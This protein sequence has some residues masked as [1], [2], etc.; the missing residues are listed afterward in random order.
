MTD[1]NYAV[2][3]IA[4]E[5]GHRWAANASVLLNGE[6]IPLGP[7]HWAAAVHL[8]AAFPY[9]R[10]FESDIMGGSTWKENPDGTFTQ[11]DRDYYNP[12]KGFSWM[13]LYLMGLA[14]PDEVPPFFM[15]RNMQRTGQSDADGNPIFR[16]EKVPLT[17][18]DVIAA[19]GPR[20]PAFDV[21]QKKF[22]T[23]VVVITEPGKQPTQALLTAANNI[24]QKYVEYWAKT[25]G[26]R[27]TMTINQ[28]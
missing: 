26:G 10:S 5:L 8:P 23:A 6:R 12:A 28:R 13:A 21:S 19:M 1:Y 4:H 24:A 9:G 25:T 22:N 27:S 14:R 20:T 3:Q 18:N 7:T 17:I 15:L 2:S 11:L 16:G